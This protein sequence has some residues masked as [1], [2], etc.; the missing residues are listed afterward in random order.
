MIVAGGMTLL[1]L[2]LSAIAA[3]PLVRTPFNGRSTVMAINL[4]G[5]MFPEQAVFIPLYILFADWRLHNA[6]A[7]MIA[8][9]LA[10]PIGVFLMMQ[11]YRGIPAEIEE[12]A[13]DGAGRWIIFWKIM[14]PLPRPALISN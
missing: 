7:A 2:I 5:L 3:Y 9:R 13:L 12:A 6:H 8:P 1:V 14:L 11:F 10:M 4:A